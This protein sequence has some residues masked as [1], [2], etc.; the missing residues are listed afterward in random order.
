MRRKSDKYAM[1]ADHPR[2]GRR[3]NFTRLNPSP[4]DPGVHLHWNAT[5]HHEIAAQFEAVTGTQWPYGDPGAYLNHTRRIANTAIAADLTKQTRT[6]VPVTHYFDLE[7]RCRDC[8]CPFIFFAEEQK[9][10][11]EQLGFGLESDCVRC[12]EC[13]KQQQGIARH[14]EVYESLFHVPNKTEEETVTM[15][16]ACLSLIE[17]AVFT[18]RQIERVRSLLRSIPKEADIRKGSRYS[19]LVERVLAAERNR[20]E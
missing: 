19:D 16:D 9:H 11:Y 14:R 20:G 3:P 1:F 18:T 2:Y 17:N 6:T 7:R 5:T 10:W 15:A 8:H 12:V 13:R 4:T